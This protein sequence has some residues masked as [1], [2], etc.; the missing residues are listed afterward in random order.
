MAEFDELDIVPK[1]VLVNDFLR[2]IKLSD[3]SSDEINSLQAKV[4]ALEEE[5]KRSHKE[6]SDYL[7]MKP[8]IYGATSLVERTKILE[9]F[10]TSKAVNTIFLSKVGDKSIDI[11]EANFILQISS[12]VGDN[13]NEN[14]TGKIVPARGPNDVGWAPIFQPDAF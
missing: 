14:S 13:S 11:L 4:T 3:Y 8:M 10:K 5:L 6:A 12:H 1:D 2:A 9:A 7:H